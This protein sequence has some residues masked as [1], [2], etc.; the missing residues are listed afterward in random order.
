MTPDPKDA[1]GPAY[2]D[3]PDPGPCCHG[4][5]APLLRS[6]IERTIE[7]LAERHGYEVTGDIDAAIDETTEK[8]FT[9][10]ECAACAEENR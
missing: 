1:P 9:W 2:Y 6:A 4:C 10:R 7:Q 5:D 8:I 3:P